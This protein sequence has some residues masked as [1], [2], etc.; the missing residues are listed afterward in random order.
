MSTAGFEIPKEVAT[1]AVGGSKLE[2]ED[3]IKVVNI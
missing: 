2:E 3:V 1:R